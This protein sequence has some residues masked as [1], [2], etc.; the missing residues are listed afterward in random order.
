MFQEK[1]PLSRHAVTVIGGARW[2]DR[3]V[4]RFQCPTASN[5]SF[6]LMDSSTMPFVHATVTQL[7]QVGMWENVSSD[8]RHPTLIPV[9]PQRVKMPLLC[10]GIRESGEDWN[11]GLIRS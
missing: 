10:N 2:E 11:Y 3:T 6:L 7:A 5:C 4:Q 8:L 1:P 9:T